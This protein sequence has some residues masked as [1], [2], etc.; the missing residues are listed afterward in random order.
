MEPLAGPMSRDS[1]L[2]EPFSQAWAI[3]FLVWGLNAKDPC[4]NPILFLV[5]GVALF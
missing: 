4:P 5:P 2:F 3:F 1:G